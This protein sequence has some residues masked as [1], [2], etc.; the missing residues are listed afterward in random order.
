[1]LK[2]E[3]FAIL[4]LVL[5]KTMTL[6]QMAQKIIKLKEFNAVKTLFVQH[7]GYKDWDEVCQKVPEKFTSDDNLSKSVIWH[8]FQVF[9]VFS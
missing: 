5:G 1:M 8:S 9:Q 2:E 7:S 4:D 3:Q 6:P